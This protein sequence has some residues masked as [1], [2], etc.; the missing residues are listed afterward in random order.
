MRGELAAEIRQSLWLLS[1]AA[2]VMTV[3]VALG[4]LL[5]RLFG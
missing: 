3:P 1:L 5:A 4:L 2:I